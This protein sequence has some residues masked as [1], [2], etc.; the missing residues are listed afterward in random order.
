MIEGGKM[1]F[2]I[3]L[4]YIFGYVKIKVEGYFIEKLINKSISRKI[5]F[6]NLRRDKSTIIY[7]NIGIKDFKKLVKIAKE[8]KCKIKILHKKGLPFVLHRYKKRKIF[9][10]LIILV[11]FGL[12]ALSKFVW[13]INIEGLQ[14]IDESEINTLLEETKI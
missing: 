11:L 9:F 7:A 12:C 2:K 10:L 1:F 4:Q 5:F 3:L 6:W 8:T 13:N 14:N